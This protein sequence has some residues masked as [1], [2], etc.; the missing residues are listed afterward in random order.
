MRI[1][2]RFEKGEAVRFLS[3]LDMQRLL[4]R[5]LRRAKIPLAYSNGF[6]PHPQLS[7]ATAL[8]VGCTSNAE[9]LDI[10]LSEDML[11]EEL[12]MKVNA[13][14]PCGV[15]FLEAHLTPENAPT[16]STLMCAVEYRVEL[17]FSEPISFSILGKEL[18]EFLSAP[19]MV[20]KRTKAGDKIV[21]IRPM[22]LNMNLETLENEK[23]AIFRLIGR[24]DA[25]G[26]LNADLLL[27]AFLLKIG[28]T[29][30]KRTHRIAIYSD[31]DCV[32]PKTEF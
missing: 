18:E 14:L 12:M 2:V 26:S 8:S 25:A 23:H 5:A 17:F 15:N 22:V 1:T 13:V 21:D 32:L 19:V 29:A 28:R 16:L 31:K 3:H 27:N 11:P 20:Q 7:F 24:M 4:Q 30:E 9:W 6:N 10:K